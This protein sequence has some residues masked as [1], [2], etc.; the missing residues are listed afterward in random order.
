[1]ADVF[2]QEQEKLSCLLSGRVGGLRPTLPR[3]TRAQRAELVC[4]AWARLPLPSGTVT[5]CPGQGPGRTQAR[6]AGASGL[7]PLVQVSFLTARRELGFQAPEGLE[8]VTVG[9]RKARRLVQAVAR[10]PRVP[11]TSGP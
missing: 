11:P 10:G 9:Q 8:E 3:R 5:C 6:L 2:L 1:M 4:P 7:G